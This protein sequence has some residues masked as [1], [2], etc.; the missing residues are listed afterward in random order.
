MFKDYFKEVL[1]KAMKLGYTE[2]QVNIFKMD[3]HDCFLD[4][5]STDECLQEV[6]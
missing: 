1:E 4:G 6:F 2:K 5:K 3:I